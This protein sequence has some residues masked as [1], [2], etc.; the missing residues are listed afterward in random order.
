MSWGTVSSP[1]ESSKTKNLISSIP[2]CLNLY[3]LCPSGP[4]WQVQQPS[5]Q[6][7]S[8]IR[9]QVP[10]HAVGGQQPLPDSFLLLPRRVFPTP[11]T[12][13]RRALLRVLISIGPTPQAWVCPRCA[14]ARSSQLARAQLSRPLFQ[15]SHDD[16]CKSATMGEVTPQKSASTANRGLC[17]FWRASC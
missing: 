17:F 9:R 4:R 3:H 2:N 6:V 5:W 10:R 11:I 16:G 1:L 7:F 8:P 13:E 12:W 14:G 15:Y